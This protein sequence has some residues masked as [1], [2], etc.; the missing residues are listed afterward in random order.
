M[1]HLI[2]A[3]L[4]LSSCALFAFSPK[5]S[6]PPATTECVMDGTGGAECTGPAGTLHL[7][8]S[9]L[10]GYIA[11]SP[12]DEKSFTSWCYGTQSGMQAVMK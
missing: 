4:L 10:A 6:T 1:R 11:L 3:S 12:T 2:V 5:R 9:D 7:G 8:P